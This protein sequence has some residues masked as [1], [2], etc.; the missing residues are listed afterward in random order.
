[1]LAPGRGQGMAHALHELRAV[2]QAGERVE[3]RQALDLALMALARPDVGVDGQD[4]FGLA[5]V[6]AHQGPAPF[7]LDGA[8]IAGALHDLA[9][10]VAVL[11]HLGGCVQEVLG[12]VVQQAGHGA[13]QRLLAAPAVH[14]LGPLVP[15]GYAVLQVAHDDGVARPVQQRCLVAYARVVHLA[16]QLGRRARGEDLQR[17]ADELHLR[18][19]LAEHHHDHAHGRA[20]AAGELAA[21]VAAHAGARQHGIAGIALREVVADHELALAQQ[22]LAGRAVER[23]CARGLRHA[24][25]DVRQRHSLQGLALHGRLQ[26]HHAGH[27]RRERVGHVVRKALEER[28]SRAGRDGRGHLHHGGLQALLFSAGAQVLDAEGQVRGHGFEQLRLL[29]A[30]V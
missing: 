23:V 26:P 6:V 17:A 21:D 15:E 22:L 14:A 10:P 5:L 3:E 16:L 11:Q 28:P 1:M 19:R 29:R 8:A 27:L 2:G 4:G 7:D 13:P 25:A 30:H 9:A 18:Q 24:A 20:V 12:V